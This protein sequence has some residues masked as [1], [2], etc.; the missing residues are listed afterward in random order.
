MVYLAWLEFGL[1]GEGTKGHLQH[2]FLDKKQI[3]ALIMYPL[4][5]GAEQNQFV[6]EKKLGNVCVFVCL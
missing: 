6:L 4:P 2:L 1:D 3:T 5:Y